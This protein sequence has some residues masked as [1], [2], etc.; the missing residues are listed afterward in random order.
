[1]SWPVLTPPARPEGYV[2]FGVSRPDTVIDVTGIAVLLSHYYGAQPI[3]VHVARGGEATW[4]GRVDLEG[5]RLFEVARAEAKDL[6]YPLRSYSEFATDTSA[7]LRHAAESLQPRALVLGH[8]YSRRTPDFARIVDAVGDGDGWP[9]ILI[10][11]RNLAHFR[12]AV[13]PLSTPDEM[14]RLQ[15]ILSVLEEIGCPAR[16]LDAEPSV[17]S[18]L[19]ATTDDDL[20]VMHTAGGASSPE[21]E[22]CQLADELAYRT[23]LSILL[24][25]GDLRPT[26]DAA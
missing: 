6:G 14:E 1:V 4:E 7:G 10:R 17:D 11:F 9:L 12:H 8:S 24:V 13:I 20:I 19:E 3:A 18:L 5:E 26:S 22:S 16:P 2:L 25:R 15:P 23:D 21:A